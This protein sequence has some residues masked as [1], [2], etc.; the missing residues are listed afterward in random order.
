MFLRKA[1]ALL[2]NRAA[3]ITAKMVLVFAAVLYGG[4]WLAGLITDF[5]GLSSQQGIVGTAIAY[6]IPAAVILYIWM[7]WGERAAD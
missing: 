4:M 5:F 3:R 7:R 1:L 2:R 6:L